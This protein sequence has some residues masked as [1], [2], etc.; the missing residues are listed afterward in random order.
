MTQEEER[1]AEME[2]YKEGEWVEFAEA[3]NRIQELE[4]ELETSDANACSQAAISGKRINEIE[5]Q[6]SKAKTCVDN[7]MAIEND[8]R[9][10]LACK[11]AEI[12]QLKKENEALKSLTVVRKIT[13]SSPPVPT[14]HVAGSNANHKE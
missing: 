1:W 6:L 9:K 14:G 10:Q 8:L 4:K 7:T 12:K 13:L 5:K 2:E 11:Q 3:N